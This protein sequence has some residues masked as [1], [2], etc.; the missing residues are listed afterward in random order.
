MLNSVG[1]QPP[2]GQ[3]DPT[4]LSYPPAPAPAAAGGRSAPAST[5]APA[6]PETLKRLKEELLQQKQADKQAGGAGDKAKPKA[7]FREAAG[8][9]WV[10]PTLQVREAG[11]GGTL[12]CSPRIAASR[13]CG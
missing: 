1:Y 4:Q 6:D 8:K 3:P 9:R 13:P 11:L 2:Y 7:V 10:D 5:T 12:C